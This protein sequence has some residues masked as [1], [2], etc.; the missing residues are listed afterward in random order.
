MDNNE[1]LSLA[2]VS[3]FDSYPLYYYMLASLIKREEKSC[4]TV[5]VGFVGIKDSNFIALMYN[6]TYIASL[7]NSALV[8][9][10]HHEILHVGLKHLV[11]WGNRDKTLANMA[12]DVVVN[13]F[14]KNLKEAVG[15]ED[16]AKLCTVD[17]FDCLK[18]IDVN[19]TTYE[20]IYD[21]LKDDPQAKDKAQKYQDNHKYWTVSMGKDGKPQL[22]DGNGKPID[23]LPEQQAKLDEAL[24]SAI[25]KLGDKHPGNIPGELQRALDELK[26][27]KFDWRT[28]INIFMQSVA[29]E[30]KQS[31][32]KKLNKRLRYASPGTKK[33]YKPKLL[34]VLDN[35][36]STSNVYQSFIAH[37]CKISK[38]VEV[39]AIGVDTRVNFEY[40][41][42]DG[43]VPPRF[44]DKS[45]G[46]GTEFQPAFDYAKVRG[47]NGI[48]YLT[49]G[50]NFDS[51][52]NTYRIPT[53]FAICPGG[54]FMEGYR[55]IQITA[56]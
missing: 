39:S 14:I 22:T 25:D 15:D 54:K 34:I 26:K 50:Y 42:K 5:G 48:I 18:G 2:I 23:L 1:K 27:C 56:D 31:T 55:N 29:Q 19:Q 28:Y 40:T 13:F 20:D 4:P 47:F 43:K 33:E 35:S 51:N 17:A 7:S 21:I 30:D 36:G 44:Q 49:D 6:P 41:F 24:K 52:L 53:L 3:F 38:H 8:A 9:V 11:R 37:I 32:W 46:G 12:M 45:S 10:L 16:Y